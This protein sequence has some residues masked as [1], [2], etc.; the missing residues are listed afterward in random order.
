M[1]YTRDV[2]NAGSSMVATIGRAV[3]NA[4]LLLRN[5]QRVSK[6]GTGGVFITLSS[7]S[8]VTNLIAFCG[9]TLIKYKT[10][11][12]VQDGSCNGLQHYAALGRDQVG[13]E[14]VNLVPFNAPKDVYSDV[15]EEVLHASDAIRTP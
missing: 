3:A 9:N 13:G 1:L 15:V 12:S 10:R 8:G 2:I 11:G 4:G 5:R 7:P 14:S 6:L